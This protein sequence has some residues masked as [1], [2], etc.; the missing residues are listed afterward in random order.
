MLEVWVLRRPNAVLFSL[1]GIPSTQR[2]R[3]IINSVFRLRLAPDVPGLPIKWMM[4]LSPPTHY[5]PPWTAG[6]TCVTIWWYRSKTTYD[7]SIDF[8]HRSCWVIGEVRVRHR[9]PSETSSSWS[10]QQIYE[11]RIT[12]FL[13]MRHEIPNVLWWCYVN[14]ARNLRWIILLDTRHKS[15]TRRG[16]SQWRRPATRVS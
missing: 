8:S 10:S 12:A 7:I 16:W 3:Q 9:S 13:L 4:T 15:S 14:S 6:A 1:K 5:Q 11:P 2:W